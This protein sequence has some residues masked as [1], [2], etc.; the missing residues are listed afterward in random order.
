MTQP[1][2][3][4]VPPHQNGAQQPPQQA[5]A[6]APVAR[7][8]ACQECGAPMDRQQRHCVNCAARRSD[9][10]NPSTQYFAS[11]SRSR[12]MAGAARPPAKGPGNRAAAVGFFALLPIA[13]AIGVVVGR[14]GSGGGPSNEDLLAALASQ[15]ASG[16]VAATTAAGSGGQTVASTSDAAG[17]PSDFSLDSGYTVKIETLPIKGTDSSAVDDAEAGAE[18]K[19]AKAVGIINPKDFTTTPSQGTGNYILYSGEFKQKADAAKALKGLKAD[20]PKAE[21]IGVKAVGAKSVG[22]N[23]TVARKTKY[24]TVHDVSNLDP[25]ADTTKVKEDTKLVN[26]L[27]A[28]TGSTYIEKQQQLPDVIVVGGDPNSAP[29]LPTAPGQP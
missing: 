13:V 4:L 12:R 28:D 26:D 1:G 24:K 17:I 29:P 23:E 9:V 14:G 16:A 6:S 10:P 20:F 11:A 3:T 8:E 15:K 21:V 27:A 2:S 7:Y 22:V 25:T 19:G 5:L 18:K